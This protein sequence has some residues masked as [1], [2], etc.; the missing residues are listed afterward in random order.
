MCAV[1][2]FILGRGSVATSPSV[3]THL[4][5]VV[6]VLVGTVVDILCM[7]WVGISLRGY[8]DV[9]QEAKHAKVL[10]DIP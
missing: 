2:S 9:S 5:L 4:S 10:R 7:L 3:K 8:G 1:M 6:I